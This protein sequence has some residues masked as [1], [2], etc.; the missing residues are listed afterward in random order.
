MLWY[1]K[2]V[3]NLNTSKTYS[4]HSLVGELMRFKPELSIGAFSWIVKDM[5]DCGM[6]VKKGY[7]EYA[8]PDV[9]ELSAYEPNYTEQAIEIIEMLSERFPYVQFTLFETVLMNDFLNHMI[10]QNTL[11]IQVEKESS[12]FIFRELQDAGY[13]NLMYKPKGKDFN[14]YRVKDSIIV[15][16]LISEAPIRTDKPHSILLEKMLVDMCADKLIASTFSKSELPDVFEQAQS[17]YRLDK[18]KM[19]R[20]ARRRSRDDEIKKYLE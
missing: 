10:A 19:L 1:E 15:S 17:R 12:I 3:G 13:S 2:A 20:Y 14:L 16:D 18:T 7:D 8:L 9:K 11:F 4:Y 5:V 6:I